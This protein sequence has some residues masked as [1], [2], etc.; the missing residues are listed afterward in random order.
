MSKHAWRE[1]VKAVEMTRD[2]PGYK[3][4]YF[5]SA[6]EFEDFMLSSIGEGWEHQEW[7]KVFFGDSPQRGFVEPSTKLIPDTTAGVGKV[8]NSFV[9]NKNNYA[10]VVRKLVRNGV[11][12]I[13]TICKIVNSTKVRY[14]DGD[15]IFRASNNTVQELVTRYKTQYANKT[16]LFIERDLARFY[17]TQ[18]LSLRAIVR[19]MASDGIERSHEHIR[20]L[21]L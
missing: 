21:L 13:K 14:P 6:K 4:D 10:Y 11:Y 1:V 19:A 17:K 3:Y 8:T 15:H 7:A 16:P 9:H 5:K 20:N 12:D 18:G 2:H